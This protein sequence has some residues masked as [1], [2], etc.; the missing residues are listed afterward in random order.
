ME[1]GLYTKAWGPSGWVFLHSIAQRYPVSPT[2]VD[3]RNAKIFYTSIQTLL[4]CKMCR[5]S[6][7]KYIQILPIEYFLSA[8]KDLILWVYIV[9]NFVNYKLINQGK[10]IEIPSLS[11]IYRKYENFSS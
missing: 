4:P 9:H 10:D 11:E 1:R 7:A 3:K 2:E 8:R 6:Y 5:E